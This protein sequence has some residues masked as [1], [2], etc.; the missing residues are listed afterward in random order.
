MQPGMAGAL[1]TEVVAHCDW[2]N[3][4]DSKG[5][6]FHNDIYQKTAF[7]SETMAMATIPDLLT[8]GQFWHT[9]LGK[10]IPSS[11]FHQSRPTI[12]H[13]PS[14]TRQKSVSD[15]SRGVRKYRYTRVPRYYVS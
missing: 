4:N 15:D 11:V 1:K 6:E 12:W 13:S 9:D 2:M 5:T 7:N 3:V 8:K 10:S 14:I